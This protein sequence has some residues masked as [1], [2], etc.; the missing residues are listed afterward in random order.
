M[1]LELF[2][3]ADFFMMR[4]PLYPID[5][6]KNLFRINELNYNEL[7]NLFSNEII[8]EAINVSSLSLYESMKN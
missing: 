2:K 3:A 1:N 8:I 4:T 5:L 7:N 6:Y